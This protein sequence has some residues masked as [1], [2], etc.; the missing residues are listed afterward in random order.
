MENERAFPASAYPIE[1]VA[2]ALKLLLVFRDRPA[3]RVAEA[4][5]YLGVARSTA[6]RLLAM[7]AQF[8]FVVQDART[9]AYHAGPALTAIGSSVVANDDLQ[10]AARPQLEALVSMFDETVHLCTLRG[11]DVAFLAGVESSRALRT[12][13]R[14]GRVLPA[15]AT[16]AGKALLATLG[17]AAIRERFPHEALPGVTRRTI[18]T[19]SA[20]VRELAQTRAR[21]FAINGAESETGLAALGCV[22]YSRAGE[23]R[24]A[25]T[26][27]GPQARFRVADRARMVAALRSACAAVS[28]TLR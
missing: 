9:R 25:I 1:S 14:T 28:A 15:H 2:N 22:I 24:A 13:D 11:S 5:R 7:L 8:G 3:I 4:G 12:G 6:H 23:A 27:S 10:T 20:L 19:R 21:G 16:S 17:D 26:I 18:R